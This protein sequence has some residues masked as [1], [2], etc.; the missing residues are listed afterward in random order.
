[1]TTGTARA[2]PECSWCTA[3]RLAA[4][5]HRHHDRASSPHSARPGY[6]RPPPPEPSHAIPTPAGIR[7]MPPCEHPRENQLSCVVYEL[8]SLPTGGSRDFG[9]WMLVPCRQAVSSSASRCGRRSSATPSRSPGRATPR[10]GSL[11]TWRLPRTLSN[12]S[13]N[14][15]RCRSVGRRHGGQSDR[16]RV[17]SRCQ[18]R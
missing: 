7:S 13:R 15:Q 6:Q 2:S 9:W 5:L 4:G 11:G 18:S 16:D 10:H 14:S 8:C 1:M 12:Q 3:G 17:E